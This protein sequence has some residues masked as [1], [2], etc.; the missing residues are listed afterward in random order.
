MK[1][2][3]ISLGDGPDYQSD[4][5]FY[6]LNEIPELDIYTTSDMWYMYE[7]NDP[8]R[9]L[10]LYGKGFSLYNRIK[11]KPK[12]ES[13]D[14]I[15][16]KIK[17]KFYD[18]IIYGSIRRCDFYLEIVE[19]V[20][21][22]N[23]IVFIDGEDS[24]FSSCLEIKKC[25][26]Y[27][28]RLMKNRSEYNRSLDLSKKGLYFKRELR[29]CDRKHFLPISFAI[30]SDNLIN[31]IEIPERDLA[32][33]IPGKIDTYIYNNEEDYYR[34]YA[35]SKYAITMRK[36][37]WDCL[38]HYEILANGCIPYFINIERCPIYTMT[39]FPKSVIIETNRLIQNGLMNDR[40][41]NYYRYFLLEYA[42]A[43][44][45]TDKIAKYILSFV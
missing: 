12:V 43:F 4:V 28:N 40:L 38:R 13:S 16:E 25:Y 19:R 41:F 15:I 8:Q 44:L 34:G 29:D 39:T 3:F 36:G 24:D 33:I 32:F 2:L 5:V 14:C 27:L 37:G 31:N 26:L 35:K 7:G 30:P 22:K 1:I 9:V 42:R 6:G 45:T 23:E 21:R 20:Y 11:R 17:S 18:L 10:S